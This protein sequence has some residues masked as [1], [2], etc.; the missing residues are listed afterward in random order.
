MDVHRRCC[1]AA[2]SRSSNISSN[3]KMPTVVRHNKGDLG[4]P[5]VDEECMRDAERPTLRLRKQPDH[6]GV[7]FHIPIDGFVVKVI[8][9]VKEAGIAPRVL[10]S[11]SCH[12]RVTRPTRPRNDRLLCSA[13]IADILTM[14]T[15][16]VSSE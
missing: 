6:V 3:A 1:N 7:S 9:D 12:S 8:A 14:L 2:R 10:Q 15:I 5:F 11:V 13:V 16:E 4:A